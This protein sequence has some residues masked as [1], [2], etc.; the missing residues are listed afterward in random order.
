MNWNFPTNLDALDIRQ[1]FYY[2]V[3]IKVVAQK[4]DSLLLCHWVENCRECLTSFFCHNVLTSTCRHTPTQCWLYRGQNGRTALKTPPLSS[5]VPT[6]CRI[7]P[8]TEKMPKISQPFALWVWPRA[9][10]AKLPGVW[11]EECAGLRRSTLFEIYNNDVG[12]VRVTTRRPPVCLRWCVYT[13][14]MLFLLRPQ[15]TKKRKYC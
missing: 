5:C 6:N 12:I 11:Q 7:D 3:T 10:T 9:T 14:V 15:S 13:W 1:V 4:N 8:A 2:N